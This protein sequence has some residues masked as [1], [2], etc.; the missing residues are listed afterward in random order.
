MI[1]NKKK[2][3]FRGKKY[4]SLFVS[5]CVAFTNAI[6]KSHGK[7]PSKTLETKG[8]M[9]GTYACLLVAGPKKL[10][11]LFRGGVVHPPFLRYI[12]RRPQG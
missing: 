2:I 7:T 1:K 10:L 3:F 9:A 5:L 12:G 4:F 8:V 11:I 6:P